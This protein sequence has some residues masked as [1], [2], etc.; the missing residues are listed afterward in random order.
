MSR[1]VIMCLSLLTVAGVLASLLMSLGGPAAAF[2]GLS[3]ATSST[4]GAVTPTAAPSPVAGKVQAFYQGD[5]SAG[6][7]SQQQFDLWWPSACSPAALTMALRAWGAP[8]RIGQ[9]LDRL[10]ALKAITPLDGLLNAGALETVAKGYGFQSTT[11]WRWTSQDVAH[12]TSQGVPVLVDVVDAQRQ[13]PYPGFSVGHWLVVVG[14]SA[15]QVEVRDSSAYHI[16][17]L[18]PAIFRTLFTGI[19]V[20]VWQ[21][22]SLS[23]P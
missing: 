2:D 4:P 17:F 6:W 14:V 1:K 20:V 15:N 18:S 12:V 9:V 5:P 13:T 19:G 7:D 22:A 11:F 3:W 23:L 8:V 16:R 21:G 10:V